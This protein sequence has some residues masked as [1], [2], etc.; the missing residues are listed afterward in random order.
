MKF[1]LKQIREEKGISI[2]RLVKIAGVGKGTIER[3]EN[4]VVDPRIGT[5][6]ALAKAL[7]V[8]VWDLV[9]FE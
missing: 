6:W 8:N 2:R 7:E 3:I 9:E 4:N 5:L 1:H